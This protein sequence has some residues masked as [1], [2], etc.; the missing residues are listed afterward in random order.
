MLDYAHGGTLLFD[1]DGFKPVSVGK[2]LRALRTSSGYSIKALAEI[3]GL[4]VNTLS[5]IENEKSSPSVNTLEQ[6]AKA[7]GV[8]MTRF[9]ETSTDK[10]D[11]VWTQFGERQKVTMAGVSVEDCGLTLEGQPIQP[12]VVTLTGS[13]T[14]EFEPILH[15]GYEFVYCLSGQVDYYVEKKKY[16]LQVGDSLALNAALPHRWCNPYEEPAVY[17]LV[18]VPGESAGPSVAAHFH[19]GH[20]VDE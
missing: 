4:S 7:L 6:L 9:F 12:L 19:N 2:R 18:M 3:S 17:L 8:P 13:L 14:C 1:Q 5:L 15:S 11:L 10:T 16:A 20:G